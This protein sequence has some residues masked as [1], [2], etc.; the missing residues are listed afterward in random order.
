MIKKWYPIETE[1]HL[2]TPLL[3]LCDFTGW[4]EG[5]A[6]QTRIRK[7]TNQ[8]IAGTANPNTAFGIPN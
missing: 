4:K 2:K 6:G 7:V 8:N 5:K 1:G 3:P